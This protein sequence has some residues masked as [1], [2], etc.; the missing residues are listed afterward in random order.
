MPSSLVENK[1]FMIAVCFTIGILGSIL[2]IELDGGR[3][4]SGIHSSVSENAVQG[5]AVMNN[6]SVDR[7]DAASLRSGRRSSQIDSN[8]RPP[9]VLA[10]G[11]GPA[12]AWG[13]SSAYAAPPPRHSPNL[14]GRWISSVMGANIT[15][16]VRQQGQ[17]LRGVAKVRK[18]FGGTDKYTFTGRVKGNHVV[19]R[20]HSGHTFEGAL[21]GRGQVRGLLRTKNGH[22]INVSAV[23][24]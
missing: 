20:H 1:K 23:R 18:P 4:W 14:A 21:V 9:A 5:A 19:A 17:R 11:F 10:A 12:S 6:I 22:R 3:V 7:E 13:A 16:D 2:L 24:R 15:V 8:N